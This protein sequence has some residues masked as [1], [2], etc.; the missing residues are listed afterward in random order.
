MGA[1]QRPATFHLLAAALACV[2]L[3]PAR[4]ADGPTAS[5]FFDDTRVHDLHLRMHGPDWDL[6]KARFMGNDYYPVDVEW[7]G[8]VVRNAGIRSRGTGS[9]DP[10]KPALR[11]DFNRYVDDQEFLGLQA[12]ELDNF[13]QDAGMMKEM[14]SM[15]FFRKMGIAAPLAVHAR[16]FVNGTYMGLYAVLESIDKRF[17]KRAFDESGGYL[18]EYEWASGYRFEWKGEDLGTY[19]LMFKP[20]TREDEPPQ[21]LYEPIAAMIAAANHTPRDGWEQ[22]MRRFLDLDLLLSY[23][24][25]EAFLSDADGLAGDWGLNNFFLYRFKGSDRFQ[26]IPW[27]KDYNFRELE[28]D[29]YAGVE[30]HTLIGRALEFPQ[31]RDRYLS[32]L[33]RCVAIAGEPAADGSGPG[34]L[35]REIAREAAMIRTAACEDCLKAYTNPRYEEEID[36]MLRFARHRGSYVL[37][38]IDP[39]EN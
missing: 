31:L 6:L 1:R 12:L 11:L 39:A 38:R 9:R 14:V 34:W 24:A 8:V 10:H 25:V 32:A 26:L 16:V 20:K 19:A 13:R 2:L 4:A 23:L 27:D 36:W 3:S 22:A 28:R 33:R 29:I 5:D 15:Q 7:Q 17:L 35:E 21:S 37:R 30:G 18:Y